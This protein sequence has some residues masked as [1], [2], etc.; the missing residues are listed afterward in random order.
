MLQVIKEESGA[1][2]NEKIKDE[3]GRTYHSE[4]EKIYPR[5]Q[6]IRK[7]HHQKVE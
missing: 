1:L 5:S 6:C 7:V 3:S 4:Y 2:W